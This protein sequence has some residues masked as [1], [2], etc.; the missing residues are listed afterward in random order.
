MKANEN[1]IKYTTFVH[2]HQGF[3]EGKFVQQ[4]QKHNE[5]LFGLR[6]PSPTPVW[7]PEPVYF[8]KSH[9]IQI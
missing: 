9:A 4:F 2:T 1:F 8:N 7:E 6:Y 5:N 3:N